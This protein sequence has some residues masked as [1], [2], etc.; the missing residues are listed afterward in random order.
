MRNPRVS[1]IGHPTGRL[2]GEREPYEIDMERIN[3]AAR[4]LGCHLEINSQPERLDLNDAH[5]HA[6]RQ[7]GVTFASSTDAH[8]TDAFAWIRFGIDQ[9]RRGWL[10]AGDVINTRSLADLRKS[11]RR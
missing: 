5:I 2:I 4:E 11:L 9:A 3:T 10:T 1:I 6:A 7:A 8:S